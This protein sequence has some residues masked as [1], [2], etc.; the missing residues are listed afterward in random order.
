MRL[1]TPFDLKYP[2]TITR[3]AVQPGDEVAQNAPVF[4][5]RFRGTLK[6]QYNPDTLEFDLEK[7]QD[8]F[9]D[10][11]SELE[12]KVKRLEVKVGQVLKGRTDVAEIEE[13]CKHDVQFGGMCAIC[14]KDM[15]QVSYTTTKKNT[16][17]ATINTVHGHTKLLVSE[18]EAGRADDEAKRRLIKS[19]KLSLVVD[20]DQTIIHATVDPTVGEWQEDESNPN[21]EAVK[22]VR[23]F[24][25]QDDGQVGKGMC[26]YIKL[27]PGLQEFLQNVSRYYELHIYTMATRAY[28][29]EIAKLVDPDRK[30]FA[31]RILSRDESGSMNQKNLKRLFP[32]DTKMVVIIDD[33]GDV[34]SWS[35]NLVK[36]SAYDFFVGIGDINSSFL[37]KRPGIE[38]RPKLPK[39]ERIA[40]AEGS[41]ASSDAK[42]EDSE[43]GA[44]S[45]DLTPATTPPSSNG[46]VS[47]VDRIVSMAGKQDESTLKEQTEEQT[48]T[49]AAQL[50]QRPLLQKQKFLDAA[51]EEAKASPA[52]EEAAA[53]LAGNGG[54]DHDTFEV[55][56]PVHR[57]RHN[58]LQDDDDELEHLGES[59]RSIHEAYFRDYD[60]R[61]AAPNG[62]RVAEL[63]P[64]HS[65]K[66][67]VDEIENIPDAAAIMTE[68]KSRVL[69][70]V[71]I[72]FSGVVPLGVNIHNHDLAIWARTFGAT[73][74]ENITKRTTHLIASPDRRTAKVRQAAKRR[75]RIAI[76]N[77]NW[78]YAAFSQW[79]RV[80]EGPYRIHSEAAA[81]VKGKA[82]EL[83]DSFEGR[84]MALSSSDEEAA[85]TEEED[86]DGTRTPETALRISTP[87]AAVD[88]GAEG[89]ETDSEEWSQH[90]PTMKRE[91]S[92]ADKEESA[93]DWSDIQDELNDFLGSDAEGDSDGESV[94]TPSTID[95][96]RRRTPPSGTKRKRDGLDGNEGG[97]GPEGEGDSRLQKRK[98]EALGRTSSLTNLLDRPRSKDGDEGGAVA[99]AGD[100]GGGGG[101][102]G[103]GMDEIDDDDLEAALAA[104][105]AEDDA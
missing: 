103:G 47:P 42:A 85:Q 63:R 73:V 58:L 13:A 49:M 72:V 78:L 39:I 68:L 60:L 97:D 80:D 88:G 76:V 57:Y 75:E 26:Y 31:N 71:Q 11:E 7:E 70:G 12:G 36:V 59:L 24:Y 62:S 89:Y 53:M 2:I 30:L 20:L 48:E 52:A 91:D 86:T 104:E 14:G 9:A 41:D 19:R 79:R 98:K 23:K 99:V 16:E 38:A 94:R 67:A 8:F 96:E 4:T 66:R 44:A 81:A 74:R 56:P 33:R 28:A 46:E 45:N 105:L 10:F 34:W 102:G 61:T 84:D 22:H 17:R 27:R 18:E 55:T 92:N 50:E 43:D 1:F 51:E 15:N 64:A 82:S 32:V 29:E 90:S 6:N 101:G 83:P 21:H 35:P 95:G 3:V 5:Y 37:P 100:A 54:T 25:L 93:E 87:V 77:Q 40:D 65:K 69:A